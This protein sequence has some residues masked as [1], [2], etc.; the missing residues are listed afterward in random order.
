MEEKHKHVPKYRH[1]DYLCWLLPT[2]RRE[3]TA[4][5]AA[6]VLGKYDFDAIA[7]RGLKATFCRVLWPVDQNPNR[8]QPRPLAIENS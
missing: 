3:K 1:A 6:I 5:K 2:N 7:C 8:K 4:C